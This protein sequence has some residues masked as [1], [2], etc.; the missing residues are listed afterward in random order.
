MAVWD[1]LFLEGDVA[2]FKAAFALM[3][4]EPEDQT[5]SNF[6]DAYFKYSYITNAEVKNLRMLYRKVTINEHRDMHTSNTQSVLMNDQKSN[7]FRRVKLLSKFN[8]LNKAFKAV[9]HESV[10][11]QSRDEL[12]FTRD[13]C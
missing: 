4:L 12:Q 10:S 6:I 13:I 2:L 8:T 7:L 3:D 5:E 9:R 11:K 1:L